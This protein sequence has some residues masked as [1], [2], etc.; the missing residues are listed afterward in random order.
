MSRGPKR[1]LKIENPAQM[2]KQRS[3]RSLV[4]REDLAHLL[5]SIKLMFIAKEKSHIQDNHTTNR[6]SR[7]KQF[8]K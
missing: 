8:N 1:K 6:V 3:H 4:D 2:A 7:V 5:P